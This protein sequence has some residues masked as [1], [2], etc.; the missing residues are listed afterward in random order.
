ML[1]PP[2]RLHNPTYTTT[3]QARCVQ[4]EAESKLHQEERSVRQSS[5]GQTKCWNK[6]P[7]VCRTDYK[8]VSRGHVTPARDANL[9][10]L[11]F[12]CSSRT[13]CFLPQQTIEVL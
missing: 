4:T 11:V 3:P 7:A 8:I 13:H 9:L 2:S 1:I 5:V 12:C 6:V 10:A